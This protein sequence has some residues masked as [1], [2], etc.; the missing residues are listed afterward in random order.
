RRGPRLSIFGRVM[1]TPA[2]HELN[3]RVAAARRE[4][5]CFRAFGRG[6]S[7]AL[8]G[9]PLLSAH[10][11]TWPRWAR[12]GL[13][14][15]GLPCRTGRR[16]VRCT[17]CPPDAS[18]WEK[19]LATLANYA[20]TSRKAGRILAAGFRSRAPARLEGVGCG[21]EEDQALAPA[22]GVTPRSL[23]RRV[24]A[25]TLSNPFRRA[26]GVRVL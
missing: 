4:T 16:H 9:Q 10:E 8:D 1:N 17:S 23:V 26:A 6:T 20:L 12:P 7:L 2:R 11:K 18:E 5:R 24:L 13:L 14:V 22:E 21:D 15:S 3:A 19:T 25:A